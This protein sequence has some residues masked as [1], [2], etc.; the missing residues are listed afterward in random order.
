MY[1]VILCGGSGT[2]LWPLSRKNFPKQFLSLYSDKSLLQETY[3]RMREIMPEENI[4]LV[5][6]QENY[7]TAFNHIYEISEKFQRSQILVEPESRGTA[8]AIT[9][10]IMHLV[11]RVGVSPDEPII[12]L[13]SDHHIANAGDYLELVKTAAASIGSHIG[14]IGVK[15]TKPET[16]YGYIHKGKKTGAGFEALEFKEKPDKETAQKFLDSGEYVWNSGMYIFNIKTYIK[17]LRDHAPDIYACITSNF[18]RFLENFGNIPSLSIENALLTKTKNIQI[19]EGSF[20]WS[21]VGSFDSIAEVLQDQKN[22]RYV[23]IDSKNIYT[24]SDGNRLIATLGVEDLNIIETADSILV[25]KRGRSEDMRV[26]VEYLKN[27]NFRELEHNLVVHRR[28]GKFEVLLESSSHRIKK[29]TIYPGAKLNMQSHYHR[30]EHWIVVRGVAKAEIDGKEIFLKENESTFI[31]P[32]AIHRIENPGKINLQ[33]I[34]VQTGNYI[35]ED[36]TIT[37][38]VYNTEQTPEKPKK[39]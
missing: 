37:H 19:Y 6:N 20:G 33:I 12:S 26:L 8:P 31:P 35:D 39:H 3:L 5:T 24:H 11:G 29:T 1:S 18:D 10:A 21:D 27:N 13:Y 34:E 36:D 23:G 25:Q 9:Y 2:R 30:A 38:A 28:W 14:I 7:F 22:P 17:E 16:G 32:L 15:P 4:F